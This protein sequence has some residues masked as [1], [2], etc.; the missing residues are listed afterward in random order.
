MSVTN[1]QYYGSDQC[2]AMAET[3]GL[4]NHAHLFNAWCYVWRA[5]HKGSLIEDFVKANWYL[6]RIQANRDF[7]GF[8]SD[9][10]F[11][12][13]FRII[14]LNTEHPIPIARLLSL[15][16]TVTEGDGI[17]FIEQAITQIDLVIYAA[18][19]QPPIPVEP[20][21]PSPAFTYT[22]GFW[23]QPLIDKEDPRQPNSVE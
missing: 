21:K 16:A 19:Q 6:K 22:D 20:I 18:S 3:F 1:P 9:L 8:P 2:A 4:H 17:G 11:D 5:G 15:I 23:D 7:Q 12:E 13:V 14:R 10:E